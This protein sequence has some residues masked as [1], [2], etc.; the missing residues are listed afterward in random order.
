L[1]ARDSRPLGGG[2]AG[3][4]VLRVGYPLGEVAGTD[5]GRGPLDLEQGDQA[6]PDDRRAKRGERDEYARTDQH[7]DPDHPGRRA[8]DTG[9][10]LAHM[11]HRAVRQPHDQEA[12]QVPVVDR[13]HAVRHAGQLVD[14]L[15]ALGE[16][17]VVVIVEAVA[18]DDRTTDPADRPH[19]HQVL[20]WRI[21]QL[22]DVVDLDD[23]R[24]VHLE[25][26][27]HPLDQEAPQR[28]G[29]GRTDQGQRREDERQ[30]GRHQL[31]AQRHPAQ[32]RRRPGDGVPETLG[33]GHRTPAQT[34][35]LRST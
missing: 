33:D 11:Q 26:P 9:Q 4:I 28:V 2:Q 6:L 35:G 15:D 24:C 17:R 20:G 27:V 3:R 23:A 10:P 32:V 19:G 34:A 13:A 18:G 8:L 16:G 5:P 31:G 12:P 21:V 22:I 30:H 25:L 14:V 29:A 7:V 1:S